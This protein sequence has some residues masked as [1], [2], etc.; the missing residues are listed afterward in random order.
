MI[1]SNQQKDVSYFKEYPCYSRSTHLSQKRQQSF[2]HAT[3]IHFNHNTYPKH[4]LP[5][6]FIDKYQ[7][8]HQMYWLEWTL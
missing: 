6:H 1:V 5:K 7:S 4:S 3:Y 8:P 2:V